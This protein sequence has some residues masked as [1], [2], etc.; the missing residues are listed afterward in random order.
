MPKDNKKAAAVLN[1]WE[2]AVI[3][4]R[5]RAKMDRET[6][7]IGQGLLGNS[8]NF[9]FTDGFIAITLDKYPVPK[10]H[11]R[12]IDIMKNRI[13]SV[14]KKETRIKKAPD[15]AFFSKSDS[16]E[17]GLLQSRS[18]EVNN[19]ASH[20]LANKYPGVPESLYESLRIN[21]DISGPIRE[22]CEYIFG[23][24]SGDFSISRVIDSVTNLQDLLKRASFLA[25]ER[26]KLLQFPSSELS[27]KEALLHL[28]VQEKAATEPV[29]NASKRLSSELEKIVFLRDIMLCYPPSTLERI[30]FT[31]ADKKSIISCAKDSD[32]IKEKARI[33]LDKISTQVEHLRDQMIQTEV[34]KKKLSQQE[35]RV[36]QDSLRLEQ[37]QKKL[38]V[39]ASLR[40]TEID[41][42]GSGSTL[43]SKH[44][45]GLTMQ[46]YLRS[47][48]STM[49][50]KRNAIAAASEDQ[51][52]VQDLQVV[53]QNYIFTVD[54]LEHQISLPL[55]SSNKQFFN[56]GGLENVLITTCNIG[57]QS[58]YFARIIEQNSHRLLQKSSLGQTGLKRY[59]D[60][61]VVVKQAGSSSDERLACVKLSCDKLSIYVPTTI[62]SH[63]DYESLIKKGAN[64]DTLRA[65]LSL[66]VSLRRADGYLSLET[67]APRNRL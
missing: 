9:Q 51:E 35:D 45:G 2:D 52:E 61:L 59:G 62:L 58:T 42:C 14:F 26:C 3:I 5:L 63:D 30:G 7:P 41:V 25:Q 20:I 22:L 27:M 6:R 40:V 47:I 21:F 53:S 43:N 33:V 38:E 31:G 46:E 44:L 19:I 17:I 23:F 56:L 67:E 55:D 57:A 8:I 65:E 16:Y 13:I 32:I 37:E 15:I 50:T 48:E 64:V 66:K 28:K 11:E 24:S 36:K 60:D 49:S 29:N 54:G 34:E 39:A 18:P 12:L 4:K 10:E 1:W